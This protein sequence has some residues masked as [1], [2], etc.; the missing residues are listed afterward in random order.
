[1]SLEQLDELYREVILDHFRSPRHHEVVE[2]ADVKTSGLNPLCG[3][4][5]QMQLRLNGG[6]IL[7]IGVQSKGC[8]ISQASGSMLAERLQG[9]TLEEAERLVHVIKQMMHGA[10]S[11]PEDDLGD[12]ESL[13]GVRKF[14]VRIKCALLGWTTLEEGLKQLKEKD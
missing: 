1:M 7:A 2:P 5:L 4:E 8:S 9:K 10:P 12:L 6:R 14:P 3:D 13:A 11:S